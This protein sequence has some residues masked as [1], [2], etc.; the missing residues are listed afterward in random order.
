MQ[1]NKI[2]RY[3]DR[4]IRILDVKEGEVLVI[5]CVKK[6]MPRWINHLDLVEGVEMSEEELREELEA[7]IPEKISSM[8]AREM[9][10]RFSVIAGILPYVGEKKKRSLLIQ[11]CAGQYGVSQNTVKN[12]LM[13]Y[14]I[15]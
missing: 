3:R 15:Y 12:Y 2:Y 10:K 11:E 6:T 9:Q 4:I 8:S 14:L 1:K 5:D 13:A 7:G